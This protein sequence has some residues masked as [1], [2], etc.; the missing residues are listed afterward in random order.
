[1]DYND[2]KD[3]IYTLDGQ[4]DLIPY[5][6]S[7]YSY[8]WGFCSSHEVK[9]KLPPGSYRV[10]ID[11]TLAPGYLDLSHAVIPG[12]LQQEIFFSSYVCHPSMAN[13]EL[14][15]PVVLA[16][17]LDYVQQSYPNPTF[18][19]RFLLCPETI[20]LLLIYHDFHNI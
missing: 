20:G 7:Y 8:D 13:N 15:G 9:K 2:L 19:Y 11:S 16:A 1:M 10:K 3:K 6:T 4:P 12:R 18:S 14:S 5:I 17:L